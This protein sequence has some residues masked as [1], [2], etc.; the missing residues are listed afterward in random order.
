MWLKWYT[1]SGHIQRILRYR[2]V[3]HRP[4]ARGL[5][6]AGASLKAGFVV[7]TLDTAN[8]CKDGGGTSRLHVREGFVPSVQRHTPTM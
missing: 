1:R 8:S 7:G 3:G 6:V 4:L 2:S 5:K